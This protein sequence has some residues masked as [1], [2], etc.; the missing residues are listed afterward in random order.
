M[1]FN[2]KNI[3]IFRIKRSFFNWFFIGLFYFGLLFFNLLITPQASAITFES[4]PEF[5]TMSEDEVL[6]FEKPIHID[7]QY[8]AAA[9][10]Y[11]KPYM[12]E[13]WWL[14]H[15]ASFDGTVG[16]LNGTTF[17]INNR[18]K[19]HKLL[20]E[21]F[22]FRFTY[23]EER[24]LERDSTAHVVEFIYW[25]NE[26]LGFSAYGEPSFYK[27]QNDMGL[28]ILY[29]PHLN[30]EIRVFNTWVDL[31]R[32][33]RNDRRDHF[34]E[35]DM[36]YSMGIVGRTWS[37]LDENKN[38]FFEYSLRQDTPTRWIFPDENYEYRYSKK[39]ASVFLQLGVSENIL[40]SGRIQY[41]QKFESKTPTTLTSTTVL[42]NWTTDRLQSVLRTSFFKTGPNSNWEITPGIA[43]NVRDWKSNTG[44]VTYL[45]YVPHVILVMPG[46]RKIPGLDTWTLEYDFT[47]HRQAGPDFLRSRP[48]SSD[49]IEQRLDV[50]YDFA[51]AGSSYLKL[52][53]TF[54]LS[55]FLKGKPWGGGNAMFRVD[56]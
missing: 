37:P 45:D 20:S 35:S 2:F 28:A 55:N 6:R 12:W 41:D 14:T 13:Y 17:L 18:G 30:H 34:V 29:K 9:L 33:D 50:S 25:P 47:L 5:T 40:M 36:P 1:I 38:E 48:N 46:F 54:D 56:F 39:T 52:M 11:T 32:N 10:S 23:F 21:N 44:V 7:P 3:S 24:T 4:F 42:E 8:A 26:K 22:E 31:V 27:R 19:L 16:S 51:F 43:M 15:K 49:I 53:G